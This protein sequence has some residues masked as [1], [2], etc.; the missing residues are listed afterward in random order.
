[1]DAS[2]DPPRRAGGGRYEVLDSLRGVAAVMIVVMHFNTDGLVQPSAFVTRSWLFVDFFFVLSGVVIAKSY[3]PKLGAGVGF[4]DFALLR[5]GRL[6]PLHLAVLAAFLAFELLKLAIG[7]GVGGR[8]AFSGKMS[9][10]DLALTAGFVQIFRG[11]LSSAWNFPSWSISAEF[12]TYLIFGAV[13]AGLGRS[14]WLLLAPLALGCAAV[15]VL[16]PEATLLGLDM[17]A[18]ARCLFTFLLGVA[19]AG[20]MPPPQRPGGPARLGDTLAE[21]ACVP[22]VVT[23]VLAAPAWLAPLGFAVVIWVF[24]RQ[25]GLISAALLHPLPAKLGTLSYS[26]YMVHAFVQARIMDALLVA[27]KRLGAPGA[28]IE[29]TP[30]KDILQGGPGI[31]DLGTAL[32]LVAV[33]L[34]A[35]VTHRWVE[36]PGQAW[37]RR[38]VARRHGRRDGPEVRPEEAAVG[39]P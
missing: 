8:G 6:Y 11:E 34:V 18:L 38:L 30:G 1:M 21:A 12:W 25:R 7:G 23:I 16:A 37:S 26:I 15:R 10:E 27:E 13:C 35:R 4:L 32:M 3:G 9:V 28:L 5:L 36:L 31:A 24:A 19:I 22:L 39:A 2:G 33:V 14:R 20:P 29:T 17:G